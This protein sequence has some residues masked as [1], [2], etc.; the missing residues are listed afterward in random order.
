MRPVHSHLL[1]PLRLVVLI[2][3]L[4]WR[5]GIIF[6][7]EEYLAYQWYFYNHVNTMSWFSGKFWLCY[8]SFFKKCVN[9]WILGEHYNDQRRWPSELYRTK[10]RKRKTQFTHLSYW[11]VKNSIQT[12]YRTVGFLTQHS[13]QF[14]VWYL[15]ILLIPPLYFVD[16][17]FLSSI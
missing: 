9:Y 16:L 17:Q 11:T 7:D 10:S 6:F 8:C 14:D 12:L 2:F 13:R 3:L 1:S 15:L 4:S 5:S